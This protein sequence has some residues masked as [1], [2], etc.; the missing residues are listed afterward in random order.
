MLEIGFNQSP[1]ECSLLAGAKVIK[2]HA[3]C[4]IAFKMICLSVVGVEMLSASSSVV[5]LSSAALVKTGSAE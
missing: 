2:I 1:V 4:E 3:S 5:V